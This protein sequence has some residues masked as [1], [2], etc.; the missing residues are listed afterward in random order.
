MN[1]SWSSILWQLRSS[2]PPSFNPYLAL[3]CNRGIHFYDYLLQGNELLFQLVYQ[4]VF[5]FDECSVLAILSHQFHYNLNVVL[6]FNLT[7]FRCFSQF[8]N[9][10]ADSILIILAT[11]ICAVS[12]I[13]LLHI[14][15]VPN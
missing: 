3:I 11:I 5:L 1:D 12:V 10:M 7:L 4:N 13:Y 14:L 15:F 8:F 9:G 6:I 2:Y